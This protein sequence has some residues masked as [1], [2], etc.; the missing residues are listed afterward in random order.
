MDNAL[1]VTS[2]YALDPGYQADFE[3]TGQRTAS[4]PFG[5]ILQGNTEQYD[6]VLAHTP[7]HSRF[8]DLPALATDTQGDRYSM[9]LSPR[10]LLPDSDVNYPPTS[11][12]GKP[13]SPLYEEV[14][15]TFEDSNISFG[16]GVTFRDLNTNACSWEE[17]GGQSWS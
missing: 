15:S 12:H 17:F 13:V 8:S 3:L 5:S 10:Q 6:A 2:K 1:A 11:A 9:E 7:F 4:G 16:D 14:P